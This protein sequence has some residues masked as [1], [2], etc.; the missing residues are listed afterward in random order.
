MRNRNC[1]SISQIKR[2]GGEGVREKNVTKEIEERIGED[3]RGKRKNEWQ[4][5][6]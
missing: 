6:G 2:E 5:G 4:R 3:R 1:N